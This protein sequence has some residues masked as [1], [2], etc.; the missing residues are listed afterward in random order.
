MAPAKLTEGTV[1]ATLRVTVA[2]VDVPAEL[3]G[4]IVKVVAGRTVVGVPL[5]AQVVGLMVAHEGSG[6]LTVQLV[7]VDPPPEAR[8]DG[9]TVIALLITPDVPLAPVKLRDT[10]L[11][12]TPRMAKQ[13]SRV[14]LIT[15]IKMIPN[16]FFKIPPLMI[17]GELLKNVKCVCVDY[18]IK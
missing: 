12:S 2:V 11:E 10:S 14:K 13:P 17:M 7:M 9:F 1:G 16:K 18:K 5:I 3:V 8:E 4:T 6:G 15:V